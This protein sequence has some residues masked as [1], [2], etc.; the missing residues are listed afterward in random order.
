[1]CRDLPPS[2]ACGLRMDYTLTTASDPESGCSIFI[3]MKCA[4][5]KMPWRRLHGSKT[6]TF[7]NDRARIG[8][9]KSKQ[10]K[11]HDWLVDL[12][13]YR[14]GVGSWSF[15]VEIPLVC[16]PETVIT[17]L[18]NCYFKMRVGQLNLLW[19]MPNQVLDSLWYLVSWT[20]C[21][22]LCRS[23][24]FTKTWSWICSYHNLGYHYKH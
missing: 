24:S 2:K 10:T 18:R 17:W 23:C 12:N 6:L 3:L 4:C 19:F 20:L 11:P 9:L 13:F 5:E 7:V 1:M 21:D 8:L 16:G 15:E 22:I 14:L